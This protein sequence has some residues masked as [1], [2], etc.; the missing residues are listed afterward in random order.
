MQNPT[1][2]D[3][4]PILGLSVGQMKELLTN[5][6]YPAAHVQPSIPATMGMDEIVKMTGYSKAT[7]YKFIHHR[8]IPFHKPAHGGR[9]VFFRRNEIDD[10]LR[11]TRIETNQEFFNNWNGNSSRKFSKLRQYVAKL[12]KFQQAYCS[13]GERLASLERLDYLMLEV[14][15]LSYQEETLVAEIARREI[16]SKQINHN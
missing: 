5:N 15:Y 11:S 3:E 16:A 8:Q 2:T 4:T 12:R 6:V 9:R 10:W 14:D 1:F 7:I 13:L